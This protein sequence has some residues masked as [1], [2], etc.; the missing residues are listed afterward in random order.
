LAKKSERVRAFGYIKAKQSVA[1]EV[2]SDMKQVLKEDAGLA[3]N[4]D[5]T[6]NSKTKFLV[7]GISAARC[8]SAHGQC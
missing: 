7:K 5:R 6:Q 1:L 2:L 3:L 8:R 4:F